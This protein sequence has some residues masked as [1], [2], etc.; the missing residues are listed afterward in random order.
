[1]Q[2]ASL[3]TRI[4]GSYGL[5]ELVFGLHGTDS[6]RSDCFPKE[7]CFGVDVVEGVL[8]EVFLGEGRHDVPQ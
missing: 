6:R 5:A 7:G 2:A 8:D 1:M 3:R 4:E